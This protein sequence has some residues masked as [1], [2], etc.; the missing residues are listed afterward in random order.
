MFKYL[1]LF[2]VLL[3]LMILEYFSLD[4]VANLTKILYDA[5]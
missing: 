3:S 4:S 1:P 5:S 2:D